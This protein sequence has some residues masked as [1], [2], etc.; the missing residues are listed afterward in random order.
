MRSTCLKALGWSFVFCFGFMTVWGMLMV[1][2]VHPILK[3]LYDKEGYDFGGCQDCR[4]SGHC[5][6]LDSLRWVGDGQ[7]TRPRGGVNTLRV[8]GKP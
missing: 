1:E 4:R 5:V 8:L 6:G 3:E 7:E 2:F